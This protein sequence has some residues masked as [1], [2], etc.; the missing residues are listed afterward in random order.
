MELFETFVYYFN[1]KAGSIGKRNKY[2][3]FYV[4]LSCAILKC[5]IQ[6]S[7]QFF[8][9]GKIIGCIPPFLRRESHWERIRQDE[10]KFINSE[11][12]KPDYRYHAHIA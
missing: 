2:C 4:I 6:V 5:L 11:Y 8:S 3:G 9:N 10:R 12:I 1:T 7:S